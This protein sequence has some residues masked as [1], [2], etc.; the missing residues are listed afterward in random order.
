[1][2][3]LF[4]KR[5]AWMKKLKNAFNIPQDLFDG[6]EVSEIIG[7]HILYEMTKLYI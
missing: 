7:L 2:S 5:E 6:V 3:I 1:M 4:H